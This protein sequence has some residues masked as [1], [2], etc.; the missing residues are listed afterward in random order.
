VTPKKKKEKKE[1]PKVALRQT[2][3]ASGPTSAKGTVPAAIPAAPQ[4]LATKQEPSEDNE[5]T[6][7]M[8]AE[9]TK[10]AED[11]A[12][13]QVEEEAKKEK[14]E[15]KA[16]DPNSVTTTISPAHSATVLR[17]A[18]KKVFSEGIDDELLASL[19]DFWKN[20][21]MAAEEKRDFIPSDTSITRLN[22][23]I[24][25]PRLLT[26]LEA[27]SNEYAQQNEISGLAQYHVV[28]GA[29]GVVKEIAASRPI[30]F[31]LDENAASAIRKAHFE[32]ATK[33]GVPVPV[34]IDITVPF[35]IYSQ[36]TSVNKSNPQA[37]T[38]TP[39]PAPAISPI[40]ADRPT[41]K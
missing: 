32:P 10:V 39:A 20:Y 5:A 25:P 28:L 4:E 34:L 19:P 9:T 15:E 36:R 29:D 22:S 40:P 8:T 35:R 24:R 33:A 16:A 41:Y 26:H 23:S 38:N 37:G 1:A 11:E 18:L 2:A 21:Y 7:P 3:T 14:P 13:K 31:G 17:E 12:K 30:G 27:E 6:L